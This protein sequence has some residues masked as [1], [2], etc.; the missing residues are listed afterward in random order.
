MSNDSGKQQC[1]W[2]SKQLPYVVDYNDHFETPLQA[3]RDISWILDVIKSDRTQHTIYDPYYCN[4]RTSLLLNQLGFTKICHEAR[5]FYKDVENKT[6]PTHDTLITN[7]PYSDDHKKR[8]LDY[9]VE[10]WKEHNVSFFILMPNY[11]AARKYF[12][13]CTEG[14][15]TGLIY[16]LPEAPYEYDHP[17]GT[18]HTIPPFQ[19][20]WFCGIRSDLITQV[21]EKYNST[22][23]RNDLQVLFSMEELKCLHKIPTTKRPNPKQRRKRKKIGDAKVSLGPVAKKKSKHRDDSGTRTKTRF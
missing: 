7:P 16:V 8:C 4:G 3:Y 23:M 19:S 15:S 18:G 11:V 2:S 14:V 22:H 21:K 5:D 13:T 12:R 6:V 20:M 9:C 1:V 10:E 17:E